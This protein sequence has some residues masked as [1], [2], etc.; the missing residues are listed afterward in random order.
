MHGI[1]VF[2]DWDELGMYN[3][4]NL[5]LRD[6]NNNVVH[7]IDGPSSDHTITLACGNGMENI[8]ITSD[9]DGKLLLVSSE[10][11]AEGEMN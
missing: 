4:T 1:G 11:S 3:L 8:K 9:S 7:N 6:S 2:K 10:T 5:E